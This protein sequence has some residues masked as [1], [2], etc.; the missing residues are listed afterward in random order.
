L[1]AHI[2]VPSTRN[3][4]SPWPLGCSPAE[5]SSLMILTKKFI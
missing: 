3:K 5:P 4:S 2:S 1:D